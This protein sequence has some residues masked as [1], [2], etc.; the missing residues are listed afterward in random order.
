MS[1]KLIR[2]V[3]AYSAETKD[4]IDRRERG[5]KKGVILTPIFSPGSKIYFEVFSMHLVEK[6]PM[7]ILGWIGR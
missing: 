1:I 6:R 2:L 4:I 5:D 3:T 7:L